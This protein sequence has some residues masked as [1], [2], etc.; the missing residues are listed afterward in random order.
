VSAE[1]ARNAAAGAGVTR[2]AGKLLVLGDL[3]RERFEGCCSG[4]RRD[5]IRCVGGGQ[6]HGDALA[7][8]E[9]ARRKYQ[10]GRDDEHGL[11]RT[12]EIQ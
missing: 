11:D 1:L 7:L 5:R 9:T 12:F 3:M 2:V 4:P 8:L 6:R 10:Q